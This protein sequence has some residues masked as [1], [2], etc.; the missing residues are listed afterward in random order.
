M[1]IRLRGMSKRPAK[2]AA[3]EEKGDPKRSKEVQEAR[4]AVQ[5]FADAKAQLAQMRAD[6]EHEFPE[7]AV[8]LHE[9][10]ETNDELAE[11][12]G[13]TKLLVRAAGQT[14]G[15]WKL[16]AGKTQPGYQ[17]E[18]LLSEILDLHDDEGMQLLRV[19]HDKGVIKGLTVD[20]EASKLF[21]GADKLALLV[22]DAWDPGGKPLTPAVQAP[23]L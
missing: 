1:V 6:F 13:P 11:M 16:R 7:A 4:E 8:A 20:K 5:R 19:L 15:D 2:K 17:Q 3:K 21:R 9:I 10:Q 12:I 14:I 23:K 18:K 22:E